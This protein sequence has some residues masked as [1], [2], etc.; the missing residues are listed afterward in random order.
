[1]DCAAYYRGESS[2]FLDIL[3]RSFCVGI[4]QTTAESPTRAGNSSISVDSPCQDATSE[5]LSLPQHQFLDVESQSR[6]IP[7]HERQNLDEQ[8]RAQLHELQSKLKEEKE[9]YR[10]ETKRHNKRTLEL[11]ER[12]C[13]L[14]LSLGPD[15]HT[16]DSLR[17]PWP[18]E[19]QND[20]PGPTIPESSSISG[21]V[22][23]VEHSQ[24]HNSKVSVQ[25][26]LG[27][28]S[29]NEQTQTSPMHREAT[30]KEDIVTSFSVAGHG[31]EDT[32]HKINVDVAPAVGKRKRIPDYFPPFKRHRVAEVID[33]IGPQPTSTNCKPVDHLQKSECATNH[34]TT[35]SLSIKKRISQ[36]LT[37]HSSLINTKLSAPQ[38][39]KPLS[40]KDIVL[41][42][43]QSNPGSERPLSW[44][45]SSRWRKSFG[46]SV[47]ALR[48]G[49]EK[50]KVAQVEPV[51]PLPPST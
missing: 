40:C 48:E 7:S 37:S 42:L 3:R 31:S 5:T 21:A 2:T 25:S 9:N 14:S 26:S 50:M 29:D 8:S 13:L 11:E 41:P 19:K 17:A 51:P 39:T 34:S 46:V 45:R 12:I 15:V 1:M 30:E 4:A 18:V 35:T 49:F 32:V 24:D 43:S 28:D 6:D 16:Q 38:K 22:T 20:Q 47:K 36:L 27:G 10:A 33:K 23:L 44:P